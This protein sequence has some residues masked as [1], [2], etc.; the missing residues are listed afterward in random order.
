MSYQSVKIVKGNGGWGDD[1][2][3]TPTDE[4]NVVLSVTNGGIHPVAARIAE[5]SGAEAVDGFS[6]HVDDA[7]VMAAVINCGGTARIGVYPKKRIPTV[8]VYPGS[9]T[10]PLAKFITADIFVSAVGVDQVTT[11]Q[12]TEATTTDVTEATTTQAEPEPVAERPKTVSQTQLEQGGFMSL[13]VR[14]G[15]VI[16][17]L[18]NTLLSS[19]RQ[20]LDIIL[21]TVLPFM[22]YVALL[23]GIVNYT[24]ISNALATWVTP[25]ASN[26]IGL[27][28]L[29]VIV[30]LP[31]LSP[32]LGPG[33]AIAQV[34]GVLM[35]Q[36]I[37]AGALPVQYA[38]PT[39]FAIDG[40]VGC[41]FVPVGLSLGEAQP[42]TVSVGV[43][44][45]LFTRLVTSPLA[46][47][48]AYLAS[49]L[50]I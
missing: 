4:K 37:A 11:A 18:I 27:V 39:L 38:L 42:E 3:L 28:L 14:F 31:F 21:K 32:V 22:A 8:D 19:G 36:Q 45:V 47:L 12:A 6:N 41:D 35:G 7:R 1:M 49:F 25:L 15:N 46:V 44:A 26:P 43:S 24:G 34:I 23:I 30:G 17:Y 50:L 10:G 9:P 48:I 29:G 20:A 13:V 2:I 40:Q 33:A 5:L 16:G